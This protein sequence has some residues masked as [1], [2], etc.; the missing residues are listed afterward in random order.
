MCIYTGLRLQLLLTEYESKNY[1]VSSQESCGEI[2]CNLAS[3][4]QWWGYTLL[5]SFH[6]QIGGE[7]GDKRAGEALPI[8]FS[9]SLQS[10]ESLSMQFCMFMQAY[11][12]LCMILMCRRLVWPELQSGADLHSN[13]KRSQGS[14]NI[15]S[16]CQGMQQYLR[17]GFAVSTLICP[18]SMCRWLK[19]SEQCR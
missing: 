5:T 11:N 4:H 17:D 19:W 15:W 1:L 2:N 18:L 13:L 6:L 14:Q 7:I 12:L 9:D 16:L 8:L 10:F 3:D